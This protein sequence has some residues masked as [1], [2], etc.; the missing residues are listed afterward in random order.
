[1][2]KWDDVLAH[3]RHDGRRACHVLITSILTTMRMEESVRRMVL[4]ATLLVM[5]SI[6]G[7]ERGFR[8]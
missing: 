4:G 5:I 1:M 3:L 7:R 8:Q 2:I 6:Y